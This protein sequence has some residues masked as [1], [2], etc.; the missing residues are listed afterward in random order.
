ML[1]LHTLTLSLLALSLIPPTA[2]TTTAD[3]SHLPR[4]L[5]TTDLEQDDLASLIRYLLYTNELDTQ[6]LIYTSSRYH[7]SGSG[8]GS[9][10]FLPD[11]EYSSPQWTFRWTGTRTIQDKVLTEY[12]NIY[13]NLINHDP[14]YPSPDELRSLVKIGNIDFEGEMDHDTEGSDLIKDLLLDDN[15]RVLYLQA[16]GGTNTIAR[17]LKSIEEK[18]ASMKESVSRK[19]VILASGFQDETYAEYISLHWPDLRVENF[20]AGYATWGYNCNKGKGNT[21]GVSVGAQ[22]YFTGAWIHENIETGPYGSLYRSWL[23][24]QAMPGDPLDVFGNL[25]WYAD[26]AQ[27]CSPLDAYDFLSE[28]DNVVFNP[29]LKTGLEDPGNPRLGGWG[30]RS[31]Q[32]S[33]DPELWALVDGERASSGSLVAGYTTD[34]WMDAVQNDFG[35]RMQWTLTANY[36]RAN[37]PPSVEI[38]NGSLVRAE[39]GKS[40]TLVGDVSDP[41]GDTVKTSWWQFFEEGSYNGTVRLVEGNS[42]VEVMVPSDAS[43]KNISVILQGTD[44]GD[45]PLTRYGRVFIQVE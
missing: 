12:A 45:F 19:A 43:G 27:T 33:S 29:L 3:R 7:W 21:R 8:N 17:A 35:A 37:H 15:P 25:S 34:R 20:Q 22:K 32:N 1:S 30:G 2:S 36:S 39:A 24:N 38:R 28:G 6:G 4:T 9:L 16:W 40:V 5:V 11:R 14:F 13:P 26:T 10:F 18:N 42:S 23:D 31:V 41:D 44:D